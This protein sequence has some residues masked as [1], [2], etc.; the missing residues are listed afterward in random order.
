MAR[1]VQIKKEVN[2]YIFKYLLDNGLWSFDLQERYDIEVKM[3]RVEL[4]GS[5]HC[6]LRCPVKH[7]FYKL[8]GKAG[9]NHLVVAPKNE[10]E[11]ARK[12]ADEW[13]K[14]QTTG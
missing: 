7:V 6:Y 14:R 10:I 9:A 8:S 5:K 4:K 11:R 3:I 1:R 2:D 13:L 12:E